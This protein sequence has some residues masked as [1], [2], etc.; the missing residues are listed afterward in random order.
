[1]SADLGV[2]VIGRNE[3]ARLVRCLESV[4]AMR[5][6]GRTVEVVYVDS[7]STDGSADR[8]RAAGA[9]VLALGEGPPSAARGR[10][11]GWQ[12]TAAPAVLFL[13]GDTVLDP[14]FVARALPEL[15]RPGTAIVWG[16]RREL[17]PE[18]SVYNRILDLD[19]LYAPGETDFCGGDALVRRQAL[20]ETGGFDASLIAG[21]EPELCRRLRARG[22]TI[23]HVDLPMTGHDLAIR[24]F[25]QY[26]RRSFRAGR[27]YAEVADRFRDS[28][29]PLWEGVARWNRRHAAVLLGALP[30]GALAAALLGS[31][32]P[33]GAAV[34]GLVFLCARSAWRMRWKTRDRWT[35][36]LYGVHSHFAQIP[37]FFGQLAY[38]R[39]RRL[40]R[41]RGLIEYKEAGR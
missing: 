22:Y 34:L 10:N 32:W 21:E 27:A 12:A 14:D 19:W 25:A 31:P 1:V 7:A 33:L 18:D 3:G 23:R 5:L 36:A 4:A 11:A 28:S 40:G 29:D 30:L 41:T 8:A 2:V 13:D 6:P 37:I 15:D 38:R 20:E 39:D 35:L 17:R 26:W 9:R 16:H 24:R